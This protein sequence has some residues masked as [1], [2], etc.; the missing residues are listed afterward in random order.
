MTKF[1][2]HDDPRARTVDWPAVDRITD[3]PAPRP[4]TAPATAKAEAVEVEA[5]LASDG[6]DSRASVPFAEIPKGI[7]QL[8]AAAWA[9]FFGSLWIAF[10]GQAG[11]AFMVAV[12]TGFALIYFLMPNVLVRQARRGVPSPAKIRV[13]ETSTGRISVVEAAVQILMLP[14]ALA[15][16][17]AVIVLVIM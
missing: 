16:G 6:R 7:W 14:V 8:F 13:V 9:L 4:L 15:V 12:A 2:V 10:G 5:A 11:S 17:M 1:D 3:V